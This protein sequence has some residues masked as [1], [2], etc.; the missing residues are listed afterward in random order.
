MSDIKK[1]SI[2]T[3]CSRALTMVISILSQFILTPIVLSFL[4]PTL[5]GVYTLV[6]KTNN[7]LS[8]VDIRP[9]AI[10]RLKLAHEQS[11]GDLLNKRKYIGASVI[12]SLIFTPIFILAGCILAYFFP[13]WFHIETENVAVSRCAIILL[14]IFLA[15]NGFLGIPEAILRGNNLEYKGFFIEPIRL[16]M[17]AGFTV[18]FLYCKWGLLSV[19]F[20][21]FISA[22]FAYISRQ[23]LRVKYLKE[24]NIAIP[25]SKHVREF[26]NK[27]GW[28]MISSFLMQTINNFDVI[29]IG[30]LLN[31]ESVTLFA[32]TKAIVF[33]VVESIETLVS[34]TTSGIGEIVGTNDTDRLHAVRIHLFKIV[35]P[36]ALFVTCYF[37]VFNGTFIGLWTGNEV[38]GGDVVNTIICISAFFLMLTSTEEIFVVSY[39][40]FKKKALC[41][42][43]AAIAAIIISVSLSTTLGLIGNAVGILVG[44]FTLFIMYNYMNNK[45]IHYVLTFD[46]LFII[47]CIV[48]IAI[49]CIFYFVF[50]SLSDN[51]IISFFIGSFIFVLFIGLY[52]FNVMFEKTIRHQIIKTILRK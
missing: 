48:V 50:K 44:R 32:I 28:Y 51:S 8:L 29:L 40:D 52:T 27:G 45:R 31:P 30:I 46:F 25:T 19:I 9:T 7:Y 5:Y 36:I 15:I 13:V 23:M 11:T 24:Y 21:M 16:L 20:A 14:S 39:L 41:L 2:Y 18:L 10:L 6:N 38:Y 34:S 3:A 12:I 26:F 1:K 17:V 37:F 35:I 33:R 22:I 49:T 47:K 42:L 4:G 43:V